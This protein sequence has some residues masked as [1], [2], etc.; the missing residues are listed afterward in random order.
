[1]PHDPQRHRQRRIERLAREWALG[2][3]ARLRVGALRGPPQSLTSG[4]PIKAWR[5]ASDSLILTQPPDNPRPRTPRRGTPERRL[6]DVWNCSLI[7]RAAGRGSRRSVP[8]SEPT[9]VLADRS[10]CSLP[11]ACP[12]SAEGPICVG[13]NRS[14]TTFRV[15]VLCAADWD[16][17]DALQRHIR[18][19]FR[20]DVRLGSTHHSRARGRR[21]RGSGRLS[22]VAE[23]QHSRPLRDRPSKLTSISRI[24]A[25]SRSSL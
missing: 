8:N 9:I 20:T 10:I 12:V 14:P 17:E 16:F 19:G 25:L 7:H 24:G 5:E 23:V 2:H 1:M 15:R 18:A 13:S 21:G 6:E 4:T 22:S 3:S 11:P